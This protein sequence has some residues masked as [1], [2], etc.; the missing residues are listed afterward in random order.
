MH[1]LH[2][3]KEGQKCKEIKIDNNATNAKFARMQRRKK[4]PTYR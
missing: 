4:L 3:F 1:R 2:K